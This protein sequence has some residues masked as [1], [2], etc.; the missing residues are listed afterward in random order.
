MAKR[1]FIIGGG[2]FGVHLATKLSEFGCE[3]VI[4]ETNPELVKDLS[5]DGFHAVE[6]DA[7]DEDALTE[8]GAMDADEVVVAL[9]ENMQD[10]ILATLLLKQ[11]GAK[12]IV[13]RALDVKHGQ[14]LE[15]VGADEVILPI[16]DMAY[17]LAHRLRDGATGDRFSLAG[18][19]VMASVRVGPLLAG[20]TLGEAELSERHRINP[21][22]L[23]RN[24]GKGEQKVEEPS[25]DL[26]LQAGDELLV[27]G[28]RDRIN[29][30]EQVMAQPE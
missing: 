23:K 10:S 21:V 28:R 5:D 29:R 25:P 22:L 15:R 16:R 17:Q 26:M 13:A 9:G 11:L 14:V 6:M 27:V 20:K 18:D 30:F 8:S 2:R 19:H 3:V 24:S 1:I 7:N 4:G 12:R